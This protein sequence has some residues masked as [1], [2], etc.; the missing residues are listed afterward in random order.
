MNVIL[1]FGLVFIF[2]VDYY[3][4]YKN[5]VN[6]NI[7]LTEK[8]RA[9]IM[10]IK[11]SLTLFILSLYFNFK[12]ITS[13]LDL[14]EYVNNFTNGDYFI[15]QLSICNLISYL[16]VD[17]LL[18]Y[19]KYHKY[20]CKLSGYFHH[21]VYI[22]L[23]IIVLF[24]NTLAPFYFLYMV[25][26]L[27]TIYLSTGNYNKNL[28]RDKTFG[29]TFFITRILFHLFLTWKLRHNIIFL[30]CGLLALGL[31]IYWFQNWIKLMYLTDK[32][33]RR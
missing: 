5:T 15:L 6:K 4:T 19:N 11:A 32:C 29:F 22:F 31:H 9:H 16:I 10:S 24:K 7:E 1:S 21:I 8:Q 33:R 26:E 23:S 30:I 2:C 12:F 14:E 17:C 20:M 13:N 27:P 25:E 18:G 3:L 28:R